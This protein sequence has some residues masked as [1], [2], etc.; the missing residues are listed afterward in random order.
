MRRHLRLLINISFDGNEPYYETRELK[1]LAHGWI[2]DALSDRSDEPRLT[3]ITSRV[4][5]AKNDDWDP[6][7]EPDVSGKYIS[8]RFVRDVGAWATH[9]L[10]RQQR[11]DLAKIMDQHGIPSPEGMSGP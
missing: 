7:P 1:D 5:R 9:V 6:K 10:P 11:E 4:D 2:S 3:I 8:D